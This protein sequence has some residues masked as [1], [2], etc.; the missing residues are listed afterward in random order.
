MGVSPKKIIFFAWVGVISAKVFKRGKGPYPKENN[1]KLSDR[2]I[3]LRLNAA[4][5]LGSC[6]SRVFQS[7]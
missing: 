4:N 5:L 6:Y 3:F 1:S 2:D 7:Q